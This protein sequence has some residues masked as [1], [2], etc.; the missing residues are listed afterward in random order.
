LSAAD[1]RIGQRARAHVAS[2]FSVDRMIDGVEHVLLATV[3]R[4]RVPSPTAAMASR[5]H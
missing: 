2:R 3:E 4:F 5:L 1:P